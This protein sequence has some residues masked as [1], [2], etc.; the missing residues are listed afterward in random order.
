MK[1]LAVGGM[2]SLWATTKALIL[3]DSLREYGMSFV[4]TYCVK[5]VA[6]KL[7]PAPTVETT[8]TDSDGQ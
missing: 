3:A 5:K 2:A 1:F 8:G 7:S 4:F 6:P